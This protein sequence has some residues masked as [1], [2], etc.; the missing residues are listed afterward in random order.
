M[1]PI[2][3]ISLTTHETSEYAIPAEWQRDYLGGASL[4]ARLLYD[5]LTVRLSAHGGAAT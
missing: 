3:K 5:S 2:L 1:Q 4:A